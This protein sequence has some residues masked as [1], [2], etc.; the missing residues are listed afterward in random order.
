[1]S[2]NY[3]YTTKDSEIIR[4]TT[5]GN[6]G[7]AE[8]NCLIFVHGFKGFKDWG[9]GPYL[10]QFFADNGYFV[11]TFNFSLNGI[12]ENSKDFT[13]LDKFARNTYSREID[14]LGQVIDLYKNGYFGEVSGNNK[15]GMIGHSRGGG[16][17]LVEASKNA[18]INALCTWSSIGDFDRFSERQKND[19]KDKGYFS[20]MNARTKQEMRMNYSFLEDLLNNKEGLLNLN[21]AI[22][23]LKIPLLMIHGSEDLA[24]PIKEAK[25]LFEHADKSKSEFFKI[26]ATGHTFDI[27]HP[28]EGESEK[29]KIVLNKSLEFFNDNFNN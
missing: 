25:S 2:K 14:E 28:F 26:K 17:S 20:I 10:A 4:F 23:N 12:G 1:M 8:K 27:K 11:I 3:I 9:F 13:E 24:V 29:F 21:K 16:V 19:W 7:M 15:I 5:F 18:S 22:E 6:E